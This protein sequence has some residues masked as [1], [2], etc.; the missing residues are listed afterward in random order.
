MF[1]RLIMTSVTLAGLMI[2]GCGPAEHQRA[3]VQRAEAP[4]TPAPSLPVATMCIPASGPPDLFMAPAPNDPPK[5]EQPAPILTVQ[6][7]FT[8]LPGISISCGGP[9]L[10]ERKPNGRPADTIAIPGRLNFE[11]CAIHRLKVSNLP[12]REKLE[13]FPTLEVGPPTP[14]TEAYLADM[15]VAVSIAEEDLA[16]IDSG[17]YLTKVMYLIDP[18]LRT[19]GGDATATMS[20][21]QLAPDRDPII[22]ADRVGSILAVFRI[23]PV[24]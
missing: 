15:A 18:E 19:P 1:N 14:R 20:S 22:E 16:Y 4:A 24:K 17:K 3:E 6:F 23:G 13:L 21:A 11:Q 7:L 5:L 12:G 10:D 9:V 8:G 2:A